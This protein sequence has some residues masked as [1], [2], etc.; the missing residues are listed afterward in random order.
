MPGALLEVVDREFRFG[1][2]HLLLRTGFAVPKDGDDRYFLI[3]DMALQNDG[4]KSTE[5]GSIDTT[6]LEMNDV[7]FDAFHWCMSDKMIDM[8]KGGSKPN[9]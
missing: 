2:R 3:F 6:L 4:D 9:E 7:L 8:M 1:G 5:E